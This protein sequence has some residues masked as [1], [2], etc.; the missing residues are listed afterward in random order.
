M[1]SGVVM[2]VLRKERSELLA[3]IG[4][5]GCRV[6]RRKRE[7]IR[8][9][10][11]R[12]VPSRHERLIEERR[13]R[14]GVAQAIRRLW[15]VDRHDVAL[16]HGFEDAVARANAGFSGSAGNFVEEAR[17][18]AGRPGEAGARRKAVF[19]RY[20]RVGNAGIAGID[21]AQRRV[22]INDRLLA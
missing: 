13:R 3:G 6:Q 1:V 19:R 8:I 7:R 22:R 14:T 11:E 17:Q 10:E 20:E 18:V 16:D 5:A 15:L 2:A 12:A 4:M 9:A 21:E